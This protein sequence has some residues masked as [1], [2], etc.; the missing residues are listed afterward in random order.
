MKNTM[1]RIAIF[2][3]AIFSSSVGAFDIRYTKVKQTDGDKVIRAE[4]INQ[5]GHVVA[6]GHSGTEGGRKSKKS[7]ALE[8][9]VDDLEEK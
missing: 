1:I 4:L 9:A 3:M 8:D 5:D 6:T 2:A 7:Q